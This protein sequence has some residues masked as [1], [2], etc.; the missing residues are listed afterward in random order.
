MHKLI[1]IINKIYKNRLIKTSSIY[2]S[3][4]FFQKASE[5]LLIPLWTRFLT[6]SDFG[7]IGAVTAYSGVILA[8]V[9]MSLFSYISLV[10][11]ESLNDEKKQK[12][13]ISS[14][15]IFQIAFSGVIIVIINIFGPYL[16]A[17]VNSGLIPYNPY[18]PLMLWTVFFNST[19]RIPLTLYQAEQ[20]SNHYVIAQ[21]SVFILNFLSALIF[22]VILKLGAYGNLLAG[23]IA[24]GVVGIITLFFTLKQWIAPHYNWQIVKKSI[25]YGLPLVPRNIASWASN[26]IDRIVLSRYVSLDELGQ[27]SLG[28]KI[29]SIIDNLVTSINLAWMPE[30]FRMM[31]AERD[32]N[33]KISNIFS[34]YSFGLGFICLIVIVF[35]REIIKLFLPSEYIRSIIYIGPVSVGFYLNSLGRFGAA[36]LFYYK[37]TKQLLLISSI[38]AVFNFSVNMIFVP[39]YGAIASAWITLLTYGLGGIIDFIAGNK[40]Q[41]IPYDYITTIFNSLFLIAVA[42][43]LYL[44]PSGFINSILINLII[45]TIF[46]VMNYKSVRYLSVFL[47]GKI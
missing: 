9:S 43:F 14:I 45:I 13:F 40:Y 27:Y 10:Y 34:L 32:P 29:G 7:I 30:Y 35:I 3:G 36:P 23:T 46:L 47:K 41:K 39:I 16:W 24:Y 12:E 4:N 6:P 20:R 5:F 37:K 44:F 18:V 2:I 17:V 38:N 15:I 31:T 28:Y 8:V 1:A 33:K 19:L 21:Y 25:A 11:Y 22:I 42:L 26:A